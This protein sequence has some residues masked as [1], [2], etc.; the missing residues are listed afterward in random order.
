MDK[1][2]PPSTH[3][4]IRVINEHDGLKQKIEH[5]ENRLKDGVSLSGYQST[6][7][8]KEVKKKQ[9]ELNQT[10]NSYGDRIK[11]IEDRLSSFLGNLEENIM[12]EN[13]PN[14]SEQSVSTHGTGKG[15]GRKRKNVSK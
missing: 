13:S 3:E 8:L 10:L 1:K 7:D 6:D 9:E 5:I 11:S 2:S 4:L 15:K 14:N 12:S